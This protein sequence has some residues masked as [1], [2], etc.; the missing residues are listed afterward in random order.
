MIRPTTKATKQQA[1]LLHG[2]GVGLRACHYDHILQYQPDVPWFEI[3]SDNYCM[4]GGSSLAYLEAIRERYPIA[5]HGVGLSIGS[6][7]A[8]N[9]DYLQSLKTLVDRMQPEIVSDHLCWISTQQEYLHEL[10]PLPYTEE[11]V[12]HVSDRIK[13]V[14]DFL[15][16]Q[17]LMENV[18]SYL[19]HTQSTMPEWAF[20]NAI[21][22]ESDCAVLLDVNNVYVSATNHGYDPMHFI[23]GIDQHCVKQ[24][25]LAGYEDKGDFLFD[26][27]SEKVHAPVWAL[28]E[29]ALHRFGAVPTLIEWDDHIPPFVELQ[30]EAQQAQALMEA[31]VC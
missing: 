22:H 16:R 29:K 23:N 25:H 13:H 31:L 2:V 21:V 19:T 27:H 17:I 11:A 4:E 30:K 10:L 3:L 18:S 24:F 28:Y 12:K 20:M 7:D 15:G 14:Q 6:T 8:L 26:S 1:G 5:M 9:K